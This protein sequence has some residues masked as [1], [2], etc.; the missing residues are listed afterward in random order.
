MRP[1]IQT[2]TLDSTVDPDGQVVQVGLAKGLDLAV[3]SVA[4]REAE[5][6]SF[7]A[8]LHSLDSIPETLVWNESKWGDGA[9]GSQ[10][11]NER[12][13]RILEIITNGSFPRPT[14]RESLTEAQRHQLRDAMVFAAHA[15]DNRDIFVTDDKK[16]FVN[17]G[18]RQTFEREFQT[19]IMTSAEF[20]AE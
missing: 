17:H 15:R 1:R 7:E 3:V 16:A 11:D 20:I 10:L 14:A 19:R 18:R 8:K 9:W 2:V 12:F 5:G 4:N 13:E 6:S